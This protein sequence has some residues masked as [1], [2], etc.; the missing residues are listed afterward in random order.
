L[1]SLESES[2]WSSQV[3]A[4]A[5]RSG[6]VMALRHYDV[7][8]LGRSVGTL[9][10]ASLLAKRGLR[11]LLLGQGEAPPV[12]EVEGV[13]LLART[14]TLLSATSP[15][16]RRVL[17][18]L[19]QSQRFR[20]R[21][22]PLSPMFGFLGPEI[23]FEIPPDVELFT[24]EVEREF[25]DI[26]DL[27]GQLYATISEANARIDGIFEKSGI[28]P[29]GTFFE[30][31]DVSRLAQSFPLTSGSSDAIDFEERLPAD[32]P[33]RA[34]LELPALF[35]TNF[36]TK[37]TDISPLVLARLHGAWTRGVHALSGGEAEFE[38]FFIER[39][40]SHGGT[41]RLTSR[42][43]E[44][45]GRAGKIVGIVESG[46]E[47][48]TGADAVVTNMNGEALASLID[49]SSIRKHAREVWPH[50]SLLGGLFVVNAVL[51][52]H[53]V[54]A[55]LPEESFLAPK[56]ADLPPI[57]L[58]RRTLQSLKPNGDE[59]L[60]GKTLLTAECVVEAGND[61][62][63]MREAVL[64]VLNGY[65]PFF[66][67]NVELIDSPHDGLPATLIERKEGVVRRREME[68]FH[69]GQNSRTPEVMRQ[70]L[71]AEPTTLAGLAAEPLRGP[72][73]GTYLVGPSVLPGLGQEG[74]VLAALSLANI[75]TRKDA[76][77]QR[78]RRQLWNKTEPS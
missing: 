13:P 6:F 36:G 43:V 10:S 14:F 22:S 55:S 56:S 66:N 71:R 45:V 21:T 49:P 35:A 4:K 31:L 60:R 48:V 29:P 65:I 28:W 3:R 67:E 69:F 25:P 54:P 62:L 17:V 38:S 26:Q 30:R 34:A 63:G 2:T 75:L 76:L 19:A 5:R 52:T 68:R 40:E 33:Y 58:Q 9:L 32:H 16:F 7:I 27:V 51:P 39:I 23:R 1:S 24:R 73:K 11:V 18:E 44:L 59:S 20:R 8:V 78:M 70:R 77:R 57:H 74:E 47:G 50:L 53:A 61:L 42:A 41:C 12:Y 72:V 46:E 64:S 15:A 37:T